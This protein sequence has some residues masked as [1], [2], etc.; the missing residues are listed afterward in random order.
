[1]QYRR[2]YIS[3]S[4]YF[5]TFIIERR[6]KIF[7]DDENVEILRQAFRNVM[8]KRPFVINASVILPDHI[9]CIWTL[10]SD[11]ADFSTRWRLIKTWFT[12]HSNYKNKFITNQSRIKKHEQAR[13]LE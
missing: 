5:F 8:K 7:I 10:P 3:G 6:R 1:M 9:H 13:R 2:V 4:C 12:K 11:D